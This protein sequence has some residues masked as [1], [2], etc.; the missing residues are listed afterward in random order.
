MSIDFLEVFKALSGLGNL[1][2]GPNRFG[3]FEVGMV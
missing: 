2:E 3:L 1:G